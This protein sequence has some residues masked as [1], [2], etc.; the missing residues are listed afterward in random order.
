MP[1]CGIVGRALVHDRGHAVHQRPVDDVGVA[2]DP[3]DVGRAP[4]H[5]LV[6]LEVE[7]VLGRPRHAGEVAAGRVLD[8]LRLGGRARRVEHVERVLGVERLGRAVLAGGLD[9]LVVEEVAALLHRHVG[10]GVAH[11]HDGLDRGHV[12]EEGVD[13]RL[14]VGRLALAPRLVDGDQRLGLGEL[15]ALLDRVRREAAE[16]DVVRRADARAGEHRHGHLGDHRQEDPD[17]VAGL[18]AALLE[19][20][21]EPLDVAQQLGV[22]D[23]ALLALLPAPVEGDLVAA[24]GLDV[25]VE[26]VVRGVQLAA[27][28]PLVEGR[29]R[30]V[31]HLVPLLEP[32]ERLG[33]LGP[34]RLRVA[35]GRL[36]LGLV[37]R[38]APCR[39]SRPADRTSP[40]RA[41]RRSRARP[42]P[43]TAWWLLP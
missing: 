43:R 37:R 15:H 21:G 33:L 12:V 23:V 29:L 25:A 28:E 24:A 41:A 30:L 1:L 6:G 4:E 20:V 40:G 7:D 10:A 14:D 34:P 2:G 11:H 3:A 38:S 22:G 19:H 26:R 32:V 8:A 13:G 5:V 17:H 9:R 39:E 16:H 27:G 42:A 35:R 36:V 18:D 31:E